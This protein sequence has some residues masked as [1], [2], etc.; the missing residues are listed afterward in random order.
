MT[1]WGLGRD[2][3]ACACAQCSSSMC[4]DTCKF[5]CAACCKCCVFY[6]A[7]L[8]KRG[9]VPFIGDDVDSSA[10]ASMRQF[11]EA[12]MPRNMGVN[13]L[14][15]ADNEVKASSLLR[16]GRQD[17]KGA[18]SLLSLLA[19]YRYQDPEERQSRDTFLD[20]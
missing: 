10:A 8:G 3:H 17:T 20:I 13:I 5:D 2:T 11:I 12:I 6:E 7:R 9:S 4:I 14:D 15:R 16:E 18:P 1:V 19:H